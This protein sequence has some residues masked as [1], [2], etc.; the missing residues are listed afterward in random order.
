MDANAVTGS[1]VQVGAPAPRAE[2]VRAADRLSRRALNRALLARQ[3]LLER[4]PLPAATA[5]HHLVGLQAP[6]PLSPYV[7]LWSR[8]ADFQ[9]SEL[10]RLINER[11]VVRI[12]LMRSTIHSVTLEDCLALRPLVQPVLERGHQ[13][14]FARRLDGLDLEE[15]GAAGRA[16]VE[17][18][19]RTGNEL[20]RLLANA[21]RT[22]VTLV[23]PPP[24][25]IW[26]QGGQARLTSAEHWLGRPLA[27]MPVEELILRYLGA[28]GPA[29]VRDVQAW[30]GLTRLGT[31]VEGLRPRLVTFRGENGVELFDLL[32]APRPDPDTPAPPRF[33]PEYDNALLSHA[34]RT[35][36]VTPDQGGRIFTRGA[37]LV[38]G[39]VRGAWRTRN[40]E[41]ELE[42]F[43]PLSNKDAAA[44]K[45]ESDRLV[46]FATRPA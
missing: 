41:L 31:A 40:G 45:D 9:P 8:L 33:L 24:R 30:S 4:A 20:G 7:G 26:G 46:E 25:G 17:Q 23:Q 44:V 36:I 28:F 22:F 21:V 1:R 32:D 15:I 12:A 39:F 29:S 19:P 18:Q 11:K 5:I 16:L 14:A 10:A 34:D 27:A 3:L 38:D 2:S 43:E 6:Q 37:L 13:G 42:L 35:R